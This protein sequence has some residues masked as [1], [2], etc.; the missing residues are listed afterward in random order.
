MQLPLPRIKICCITSWAE[1][2]LAIH[3]QASAI[4]LVSEMPSGPGIIPETLI[5]EIAAMVPPAVSSFLLTSL[6]DSRAIAEQVIRCGTNSV[7]LCDRLMTGSYAE[8]R[9]A[10]PGV[11]IV[12]VVHVRGEDAVANAQAI[13]DKVDGL[14]LD[15]GRPADP[16]REL[17]GTGRI[18]DWSISRRICEMVDRPVFL[19]GGLRPENVAAA[20]QQVRPFGVDVCSGV[21]TN[22]H[23]DEK[24]LAAF[25]QS[26]V[27]T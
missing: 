16:R 20:I 10:L 13:A 11:K 22:G 7:Q 2:E 26:V 18:H 1:A 15:S 24:K 21:R 27:V 3:H 6:Q 12:Q 25:V 23:L 14:L 4:G 19:A 9:A 8:L 17:G 5:A